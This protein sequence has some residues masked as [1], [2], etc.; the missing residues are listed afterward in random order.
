LTFRLKPLMCVS[1]PVVL[2]VVVLRVI[3]GGRD[4][5][6][7]FRFKKVHFVDSFPV[8]APTNGGFFSGD[9]QF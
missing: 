8:E 5:D 9:G 3:V 6:T 4:L 2:E 7:I 1:S